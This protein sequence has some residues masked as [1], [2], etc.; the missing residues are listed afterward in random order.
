MQGTSTNI[1]DSLLAVCYRDNQ[2]AVSKC[3]AV[4]SDPIY[5][6]TPEAMPIA[7]PTRHANPNPSP[8]AGPNPR[9]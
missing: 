7:P 9:D 2:L 5:G 4:V 3:V 8:Y 6:L 1:K